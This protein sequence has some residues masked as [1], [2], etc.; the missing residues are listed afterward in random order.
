MLV[1]EFVQIQRA[2]EAV[3]EQVT[4]DPHESLDETFAAAY[5]DGERVCLR[6]APW[7]RPLPPVNKVWVDVG[8]AYPRGAGIVIPVHSWAV[9]AS[10]FFPRMDA[11][12]E[13]LPLGRES[14]RIRLMGRYDPPLGAAAH[15][16]DRALLH[17]LAETSIRAFL[18]R[19]GGLLEL[20]GQ[21]VGAAGRRPPARP[22]PPG[23]QT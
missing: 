18:N 16:L 17:E 13:V 9:G 23:S 22:A 10:H 1:E 5:R 12:L 2:F 6:R 4:R 15:G 7:V 8:S 11:D 21:V 20:S 3:R 19:L 14:T